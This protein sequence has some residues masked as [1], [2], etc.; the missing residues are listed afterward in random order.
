MPGDVVI[1]VNVVGEGT[2]GGVVGGDLDIACRL[3]KD[4]AHPTVCEGQGFTSNGTSGTVYLQAVADG[5]SVFAGW[6][7][8]CSRITSIG[9][10]RCFIDFSGLTSVTATVTAQFNLAGATNTISVYNNTDRTVTIQVGSQPPVG[11]VAPGGSPQFQ[12]PSAIG[13]AVHVAAVVDDGLQVQFPTTI[14]TVTALAWQ[15]PEQP[16]VILSGPSPYAFSCN[17]F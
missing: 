2:G 3:P 1:T 15:G 13:T 17:G 8:G 16:I 4:P 5:G 9:G 11:N 7:S 6:S 14:C 10:E 12:I